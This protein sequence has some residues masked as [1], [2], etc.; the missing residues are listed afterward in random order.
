MVPHI[1][2]SGAERNVRPM[3][4]ALLLL[5]FTVHNHNNSNASATRAIRMTYMYSFVFATQLQVAEQKFRA[6]ILIKPVGSGEARSLPWSGDVV[7]KKK[8]EQVAAYLALTQL[9]AETR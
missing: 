7:G 1:N 4:K 5:H 3:S 8:A 9:L 6:R 2:M